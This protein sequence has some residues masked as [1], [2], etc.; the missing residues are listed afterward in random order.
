M[1]TWKLTHD[2]TVRPKGC[3]GKYG[4]S[5]R[6]LHRRRN[7]PVC[8]SCSESSNHAKRERRRG[9]PNPHRI[10]PCGSMAAATRHR[11]NNEELDFACKV[12]EANYH[13]ELRAHKENSMNNCDHQTTDNQGVCLDCAQPIENWEPTDAQIAGTYEICLYA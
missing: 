2:P 1:T 7:E 5:G 8:G 10:R 11:N 6:N 4:D 12:A 3:S 9:Q 13:A